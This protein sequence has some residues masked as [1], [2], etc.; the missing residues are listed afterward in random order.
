MKKQTK[1]TLRWLINQKACQ[2][3]LLHVCKNHYIDLPAEVFLNKLMREGRFHDANWLLCHL[4]K[5]KKQRVQYAIFC[6]ELINKKNKK[7][8]D[9]IN[10][11]EIIQAAKN[12]LKNPCKKTITTTEKIIDKITNFNDSLEG[13]YILGS[14]IYTDHKLNLD[15]AIIDTMGIAIF[16]HIVSNKHKEEKIIQYGISLLK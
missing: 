1:I 9:I 10:L 16:T 6:T 14:L 7:H 8:L 11:K 13:I 5:F 3:S 4:F 15:D 12:Y 2:R